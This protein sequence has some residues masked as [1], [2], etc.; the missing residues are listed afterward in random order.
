MT[1]KKDLG[2]DLFF[3]DDLTKTRGEL[4]YEARKC[5]KAK[6]IK[7]AWSFDGRIFI[8]DNA[9]STHEITSTDD[10][11]PAI[12]AA[13]LETESNHSETDQAT[14]GQPMNQ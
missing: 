9:D 12:E 10:I 5:K 8:K 1:K 7:G 4:L 13:A 6:R 3:N 11:E 14:G 2:D